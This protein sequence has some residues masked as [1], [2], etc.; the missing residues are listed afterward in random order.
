MF[1]V[2]DGGDKKKTRGLR[3]ARQ[4][5]GTSLH[6]VFSYFPILAGKTKQ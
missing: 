1:S 4:V 2:K 6:V 5:K 3:L